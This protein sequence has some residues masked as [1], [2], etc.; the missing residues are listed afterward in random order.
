MMTGTRRA[1]SVAAAGGAI[2]EREHQQVAD[3]LERRHDRH[4]EQHEQRPLGES[5]AQAEHAGERGV[6]GHHQEG[7]VEHDDAD[8]R[9]RARRSPDGRGRASS[10]PVIDPNRNRLRSPTYD[11]CCVDMITTASARNPTKSTPIDVSS[12][13]GEWR[14]IT[15]MPSTIAPAATN[16]PIEV[17]TP[18]MNATRC[19][20]ARR[21]PVHRRGSSSPA[22]PPRCPPATW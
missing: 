4:R 7:S 13:S 5:R 18:M 10:T 21:G 16:A 1:M 2:E 17:L 20:A 6:E 12:G 22:A 3:R 15:L 8:E 9:D 14:R 19:P 11:A